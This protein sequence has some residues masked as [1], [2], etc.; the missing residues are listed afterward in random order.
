[1]GVWVQSTSVPYKGFEEVDFPFRL[2][3]VDYLRDRV[4]EIEY[5]SPGL[6]AGAFSGSPPLV[7]REQLI[8]LIFLETFLPSKNISY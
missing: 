6:Q 7:V 2:S 1:M 4:P 8:I 5:I 3:D